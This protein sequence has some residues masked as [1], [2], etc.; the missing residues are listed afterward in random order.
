MQLAAAKPTT[1][2]TSRHSFPQTH[3]LRGKI[4]AAVNCDDPAESNRLITDLHAQLGRMLRQSLGTELEANFHDWAVWGSLKAGETVRGVDPKKLTRRITLFATL[5]CVIAVTFAAVNTSTHVVLATTL[6]GCTFVTS[7]WSLCTVLSR[8][9]SREILRGN[10]TVLADIGEQ[11]THFLEVLRADTLRNEQFNRFTD[12]LIAR[13]QPL[14]SLAFQDYYA[15]F[16]VTDAQTKQL[17]VLSANCYAVAHEHQRLQSYIER[18]MP[19]FLRRLT[20]RL[21]MSYRVGHRTLRVGQAQVLPVSVTRSSSEVIRR[22]AATIGVDDISCDSCVIPAAHDWSCFPSRMRHILILFQLL[23][24]D[25]VPS[26]DA[27]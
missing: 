6:I 17:H 7:I 12:N 22:V 26:H 21:C 4:S 10:Q 20:T 16:L 11:T 14:L 23:N 1:D 25:A 19:R 18:A 27:S 15:A 2:V 13:G 24:H 9:S 3:A 5:G 8:T